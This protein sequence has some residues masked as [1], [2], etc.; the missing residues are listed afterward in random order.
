[1]RTICGCGQSDILKIKY[2]RMRVICEL[3]VICVRGLYA[4]KYGTSFPQQVDF[5]IFDFLKNGTL[6]FVHIYS[7]E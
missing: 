4:R 5:I 2:S 7:T 1:M 3:R 6:V